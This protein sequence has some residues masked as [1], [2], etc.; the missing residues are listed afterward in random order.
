MCSK[1]FTGELVLFPMSGFTYL[2]QMPFYFKDKGIET[3][4]VSIKGYGRFFL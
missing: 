2:A 4:K 3:A 1:C